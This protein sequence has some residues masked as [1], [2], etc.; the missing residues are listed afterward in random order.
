L[1]FFEMGEWEYFENGKLRY[2]SNQSRLIF[3]RLAQRLQS[4]CLSRI[5]L[6]RQPAEMIFEFDLGGSL[7]VRP[8]ADAKPADL[9]WYL[10]GQDRCLTMYVNG[11]LVDEPAGEAKHRKIKAKPMVYSPNNL[12]GSDGRQAP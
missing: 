1:L 6:A 11:T 3:R 5:E 7:R 4:Q 9:L 8:A 12:V 2:T 10:D